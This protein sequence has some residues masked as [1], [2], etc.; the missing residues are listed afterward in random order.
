MLNWAEEDEK[1]IVSYDIITFIDLFIFT[2]HPPASTR[3]VPAPSIHISAEINEN[4]LL[5]KNLHFYRRS[6]EQK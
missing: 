3:S 2:Y 4:P 5:T 6:F 1:L